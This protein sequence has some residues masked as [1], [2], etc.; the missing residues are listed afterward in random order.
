MKKRIATALSI[1]A[2]LSIGA[3]STTAIAQQAPVSSMTESTAPTDS[4]AAASSAGMA[5]SQAPAAAAPAT[6]APA[7]AAGAPSAGAPTT[8]T[9]QDV[10]DEQL[11]KFVA[12]AQQVAVMSQQYSKKLE[13]VSDQTAQQQVVQQANQDMAKAVQAHGLSIQEFNTISDAVDSDPALQQRAQQ[14]VR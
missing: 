5:T 7:P 2:L 9:S 10:S 4:S 1:T 6:T 12:S 11:Q 14:L 8:L 3:V 13:G